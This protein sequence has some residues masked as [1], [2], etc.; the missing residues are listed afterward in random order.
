MNPSKQLE[1]LGRYFIKTAIEIQDLNDIISQLQLKIEQ[2]ETE[3][4]EWLSNSKASL[5]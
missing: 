2:L 4:K 5:V 1:A 3:K